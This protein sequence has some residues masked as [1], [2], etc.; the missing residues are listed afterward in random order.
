MAGTPRYVAGF[1]IFAG[2]AFGT[3]VDGKDMEGS[4]KHST[5]DVEEKGL[6]EDVE[7]KEI[8]SHMM[9]DQGN[10]TMQYRCRQQAISKTRGSSI[11]LRPNTSTLSPTATRHQTSKIIS[12]CLQP[13]PKAA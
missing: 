10:L 6:R 12:P 9:N 1:P 2:T 7:E 4:V 11:R 3:T 8:V 5:Q 13:T